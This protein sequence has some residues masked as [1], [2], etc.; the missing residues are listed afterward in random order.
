MNL[1]HCLYEFSASFFFISLLLF[2]IAPYLNNNFG[3]F[4]PFP[5]KLFFYTDWWFY[6][7]YTLRQDMYNSIPT[8][9]NA[10][11]IYFKRCCIWEVLCV[12]CFQEVSL[13]SKL[14]HKLNKCFLFPHVHMF[15]CAL[16]C[17]RLRH[18][19]ESF[20]H[21]HGHQLVALVKISFSCF[22]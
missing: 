2:D 13:I 10:S 4:F 22:P 9:H 21:T 19:I 8:T 7:T 14:N 5:F 15:H 16:L 1:A 12:K 3:S 6:Y 20:A 11:N 17:S 18:T